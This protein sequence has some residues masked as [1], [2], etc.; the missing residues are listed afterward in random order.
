[1]SRTKLI[2]VMVVVKVV[3]KYFKYYDEILIYCHYCGYGY[4]NK[5]FL[6]LSDLLLS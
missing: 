3:K 5:T 4:G 2:I 6:P 1:M